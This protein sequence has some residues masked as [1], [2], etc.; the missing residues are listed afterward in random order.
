MQSAKYTWACIQSRRKDIGEAEQHG[1]KK[2]RH[3]S[4]PLHQV[5]QITSCQT[6]YQL[7]LYLLMETGRAHFLIPP[8]PIGPPLAAND[9]FTLFTRRNPIRM[10]HQVHIGRPQRVYI[11]VFFKASSSA[12]SFFLYNQLYFLRLKSS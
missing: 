9:Q 12:F 7:L 5:G 11:P 6:Y 10:T 8:P 3:L 1:R 2:T 4:C